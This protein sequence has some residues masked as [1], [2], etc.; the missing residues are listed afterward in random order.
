MRNN[1]D[2]LG[3]PKPQQADVPPPAVTNSLN[4]TVPTEFVEL[5]SRGLCYPEDHPLWEKDCLEIRYMTAKDEDILS[6]KVLLKKGL[7]I[8]RFLNNVIIEKSINVDSMSVADKNAI[9]VAARIT[10][11]GTEYKTKV[12]CPH[13]LMR[14]E[15]EFDLSVADIDH[16]GEPGEFDIEE[17]EKGVFFITAPKTGAKIE[18]RPMF[19]RD[20]K[21]IIAVADRRKKNK[22][23]EN[24]ATT[25]L[26]FIISSVN[27][28]TNK[29]DIKSFIDVLPAMDSRYIR[30]AYD[31][32]SPSVELKQ[33]FDCP[34][35]DT[36]TVLEV[37][38]T[39]DFLWPK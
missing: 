23:P 26:Q 35:C 21:Q 7:A 27:G 6:S 5:P 18:C 24:S 30:K 19:G 22:L 4:F 16:G 11:Y 38:F 8:D 17:G 28:S 33:D 13:C 37:P 20:E 36:R 3:A 29:G 14:T 9:L 25:Q 12:I 31:Q 39:S 32:F 15:Y 34:E 1:Q 2:R 10:G